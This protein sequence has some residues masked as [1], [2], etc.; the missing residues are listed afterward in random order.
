MRDL[1]LG[2]RDHDFG[3]NYVSASVIGCEARSYSTLCQTTVKPF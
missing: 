1:D 2:F 3:F